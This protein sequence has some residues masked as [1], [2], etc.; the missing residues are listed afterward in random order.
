[1]PIF[2]N[3]LF[4]IFSP[5]FGLVRGC[6]MAKSLVQL[7]AEKAKGFF[8]TAL[9]SY[10]GRRSPPPRSRCTVQHIPSWRGLSEAADQRC[11]WCEFYR[12][13]VVIVI[14]IRMVYQCLWYHGH[15][16]SRFYRLMIADVSNGLN[17]QPLIIMDIMETGRFCWVVP[18]QPRLCMLVPLP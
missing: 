6:N 9:E 16:N 7:L 1:M 15:L 3:F 2:C 8:K 4:S 11:S 18:G 10:S 13:I 14:D 5:W 12:E 17:G